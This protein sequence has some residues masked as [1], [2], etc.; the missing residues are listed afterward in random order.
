MPPPSWVFGGLAEFGYTG[1]PEIFTIPEALPGHGLQLMFRLAGGSG[2]NGATRIVSQNVDYTLGYGGP[3]FPTHDGREFLFLHPVGS[4]VWTAFPDRPYYGDPITVRVG[5]DSS[6]RDGAW[7][8][9]AAGGDGTSPGQGGGGASVIT[10]EGWADLVAG[11]TGGASGAPTL[12]YLGAE[13]GNPRQHLG[14]GLLED[15]GEDGSLSFRDYRY[16]GDGNESPLAGVFGTPIDNGGGR[17]ATWACQRGSRAASAVGGLGADGRTFAELGVALIDP[18]PFDPEPSPGGASWG[19]AIAPGIYTF[20]EQPGPPVG[21]YSV[22]GG[23]GGGSWG[24]HQGGGGGA[25]TGG[26]SGYYLFPVP[27]AVSNDDPWIDRYPIL[28]YPASWIRLRPVYGWGAGGD[29]YSNVGG[30]AL[31]PPDPELEPF[32][33]VEWWYV[34][35]TVGT[36]AGWVLGSVGF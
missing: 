9:G 18:I 28:G 16:G 32:V 15:D 33:S 21:D 31:E 5:G 26:S 20:P 6:G 30:G 35:T 4:P 10:L 29:G 1:A 22:G 23:G 7:P 36:A 25:G 34:P 19:N 3:S 17:F 27:Y 12:G 11:G 8:N 24:T 2:T 13:G 14:G